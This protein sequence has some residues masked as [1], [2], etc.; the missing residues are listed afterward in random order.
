ML[1][2]VCKKEITTHYCPS[3]GWL[4]G[5]ISPLGETPLKFS[6]SRANN[7]KYSRKIENTRLAPVNVEV[8]VSDKNNIVNLENL[9]QTKKTL[10]VN[11]ESSQS[12]DFIF[13]LDGHPED[14]FAFQVSIKSDDACD[15]DEPADTDM[16]R[17]YQKRKWRTQELPVKLCI[18]PPGHLSANENLLIFKSGANATRTITLINDSDEPIEIDVP[19]TNASIV[20]SFKTNL[21]TT[22]VMP[23]KSEADVSII[24]TS[25]EDAA[26]GG[27]ITFF[28]QSSVE[29]SVNVQ[30]YKKKRVKDR[31]DSND[32]YVVAIDFGT[33]KT[34]VA[35]MDVNA[36][37]EGDKPNP[38]VEIAKLSEFGDKDIPSCILYID[39]QS[40]IGNSAKNRM[41]VVGFYTENIKTL[42]AGDTIELRDPRGRSITKDSRAVLT[43]FLTHLK[44]R[45]FQYNEFDRDAYYKFIFSLPVK[46]KDKDGVL[47]EKQKDITL[48]CAKLAGFL[49]ENTEIDVISEPEAAM[50]S[51]VDYIKK[52]AKS[53]NVPG[54]DRLRLEIGDKVCVFDYGGGTL[55]VCVG[56]YIE[57]NDMPSVDIEAI[58]GEYADKERPDRPFTIG[59][60]R[61]DKLMGIDLV[62]EYDKAE[63]DGP[64]LEDKGQT[65]GKMKLV[66]P[67][68]VDEE[69][70]LIK[71][72]DLGEDIETDYKNNR[73]EGYTLDS[74]EKFSGDECVYF[75]LRGSSWQGNF[76]DGLV[77][78]AK[79]NLSKGWEK[80]DENAIVVQGIKDDALG[81]YENC[82]NLSRDAF[83]RVVLKDL[84]YAVDTLENVLNEQAIEKPK[85]TFLVGGSGLIHLAKEE[86]QR[87]MIDRDKKVYNAYDFYGS[88][89]YDSVREFA[90]YQVVK[91]TALSYLT[92]VEDT[93]D[94]GVRIRP[95]ENIL[96]NPG[97]AV[98]EF[99]KG[100]LYNKI[101]STKKI[102]NKDLINSEWVVEVYINGDWY[103][104][105]P[106][107]ID[108][109]A[110]GE[111][112]VKSFQIKAILNSEQLS[113]SYF[114]NRQEQK[115]TISI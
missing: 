3:C 10:T 86:L 22:L 27:K 71:G 88:D 113:V 34:A 106:L 98:I 7:V 78:K 18:L 79:E 16:Y 37:L 60:R 48:E 83:S 33:T 57:N 80:G 24:S 94:F 101:K 44:T 69:D 62:Y 46:D 84:G 115:E 45:I 108:L 53:G 64:L 6:V 75:D 99:K 14:F 13:N 29:S 85:Y 102:N 12:L 39:N 31:P 72:S 77:Q 58:I 38:V 19:R 110:A 5:E 35:F 4:N 111:Q 68:Y 109:T 74:A 89:G 28:A 9:G 100:D 112:E 56:N 107:D 67:V 51:V 43:D 49:S 15:T 90:I 52:S 104:I 30:L 47:Y 1:C 82:I 36:A 103:A 23:K 17:G 66:N 55:D 92:T 41:K 97:D 76:I 32:D 95:L 20:G 61:L 21:P 42:I 105:K 26:N 2:R 114:L 96:K 50:Y 8:K 40:L 73:D 63:S 93:V 59:G 11:G 81:T 54:S 25:K 87:F 91:G 65:G 70:N